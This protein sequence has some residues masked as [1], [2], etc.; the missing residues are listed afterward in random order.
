MKLGFLTAC[1]PQR[2]LA[3]ICAWAAANDFEALEVAAWPNLGDRPFTATHLD[4]DGFGQAEAD[5]TLA[6][7]EQHGL[8]CSS[9]AYYDNNLHPD[10]TE[11]DASHAHLHRCID[12]A[13]LVGC[14][15]VGTFVG[16]DP[17]KSVAENL[18]D[19]ELVF[20]PLV[21]HAGQVGVKLI[22]ENC[23][24]EGWHPDGY[25]G[26]L[27]Y[28]P[29]L[30][31]WMFSIGLYLNYDPSHLMWMGI[32]PVAAVKPYIDHIPHAQ[33]KD[34]Q[35]DPIARNRFGWPGRAVERADPWDVGWWRY[36]VP[37]RGEVDWR[38]LLDALYEGGFDGVLSVEHEDPVWGGT[39]DKIEVGLRI[40]HDTLRPLM[41]E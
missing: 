16:R 22:I 2:S 14:G 13:A 3:D 39:E 28:S 1:L 33:A 7:F 15:T 18:H 10:A 9:I 12:A 4:A 34:I 29:E 26:N 38:G 5:A 32:D 20:A 19:A 37:G 6:L 30:W 36:R 31:E 17:G 27:A 21:D 41:V 24:M 35:L 8:I 40:A 23:V 11:R 25:P